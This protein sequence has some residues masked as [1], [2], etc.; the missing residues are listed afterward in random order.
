MAQTTASLPS[1]RNA[2]I[3]WS[4]NGT[5]WTDISGFASAVDPTGH[6]R[7]SGE[8]YTYNGDES[9]VGAGKLSP[10]ETNVTIVYTEPAGDAYTLAWLAKVNCTDVYLRIT[11][12]GDNPGNNSWTSKKGIITACPP[13]SGE[14]SSGDPVTVQFTHR[15]PGWAKAALTT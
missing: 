6:E 9:I 10:A 4:A 15:C 1:M 2:F 12:N 5:A 14:A 8:V 7:A 11:P 13:P 3:E